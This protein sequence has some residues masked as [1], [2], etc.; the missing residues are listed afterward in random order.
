AWPLAAW[1]QQPTI[2][3]SAPACSGLSF[4]RKSRAQARSGAFFSCVEIVHFVMAITSAEVFFWH[5]RERCGR[6]LTVLIGGRHDGSHND[7]SGADTKRI[8]VCKFGQF[9]STARRGGQA[10]TSPRSDELAPATPTR[11]VFARGAAQVCD[12]WTRHHCQHAGR[13]RRP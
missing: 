9:E 6:L 4:E 2:S 10:K 7:A 8:G 1:A 13:R 12:Q 11:M 3:A 5:A